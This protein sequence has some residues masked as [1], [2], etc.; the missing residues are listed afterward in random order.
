MDIN[1][2]MIQALKIK[3]ILAD[4]RNRVKSNI[5]RSQPH[6]NKTSVRVKISSIE[7]ITPFNFD[8]NQETLQTIPA[9]KPT[10]RYSKAKSG[11]SYQ[12]SGM[13]ANLLYMRK[14]N[15]LNTYFN[16]RKSKL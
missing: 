13:N 3:S 6:P 14:E 16:V 10:K 9:T 2:A 5:T 11:V 8:S 7:K 4:A 15:H 12:M 1:I